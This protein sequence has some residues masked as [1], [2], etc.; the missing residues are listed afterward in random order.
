MKVMSLMSFVFLHRDLPISLSLH[1]HR[2]LTP[3]ALVMRL[4][5]SR[6]INWVAGAMD[7]GAFCRTKRRVPIEQAGKAH[8]LA[9]WVD[10]DLTFEA[11]SVGGSEILPGYGPTCS[12]QTLR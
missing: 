2:L 11:A 10:L 6:P 4:D 12:R 8:A 3:P 1:P 7:S 5:L 9:I